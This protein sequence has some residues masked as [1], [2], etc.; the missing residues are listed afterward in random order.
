MSV[1]AHGPIVG[2]VGRSS[3]IVATSLAKRERLLCVSSIF[4]LFAVSWCVWYSSWFHW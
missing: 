2:A 4:G 3:G 1:M